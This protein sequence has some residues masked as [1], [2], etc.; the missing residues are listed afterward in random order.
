MPG[1]S[2]TRR[3]VGSPLLY[4]LATRVTQIENCYLPMTDEGHGPPTLLSSHGPI[5]HSAMNTCSWT[6]HLIQH[7]L[8]TLPPCRWG[9]IFHKDG[10][11]RDEGG[12]MQEICPV[13]S[14]RRSA[15]KIFC[16]WGSHL[17]VQ[18]CFT[19]IET[20]GL[21]GT[22]SP[23]RP[24]RLSHTS[25]ALEPP[26]SFWRLVLHFDGLVGSAGRSWGGGGEW[27]GVKGGGGGGGGRIG[28]RIF[29]SLGS[30]ESRARAMATSAGSHQGIPF[31]SGAGGRRR[32]F[33]IQNVHGIT[34]IHAD[35]QLL[36]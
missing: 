28:R 8:P 5:E 29:F 25:S 22:G 12:N 6:P 34:H 24:P 7:I 1:G 19:S 4:P 9:Q 30:K 14:S 13:V 36:P 11:P 21:L 2:C 32:T 10:G 26:S 20:V 17:Q 35:R 33:T 27:V 15:L 16:G 18:C 3:P 31:C 23:G